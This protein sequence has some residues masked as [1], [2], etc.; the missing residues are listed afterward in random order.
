M[1]MTNI[2]NLNSDED[3]NKKI[4]HEKVELKERNSIFNFTDQFS[5]VSIH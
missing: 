5:D 1:P 4:K 3:T 2:K